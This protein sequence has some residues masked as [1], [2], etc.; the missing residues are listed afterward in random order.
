MLALSALQLEGSMNRPLV[1][2]TFTLTAAV[3]P[4]AAQPIYFIQD[5]GVLQGYISQ[6]Y[7]I[8]A[9]GQVAG[10]V[11]A[12][13]PGDTGT[14]R[15]APNGVITSLLPG[16]GSSFASDINGSGQVV[17][18]YTTGTATHAFR[19]TATGG[20]DPAADLGTLGGDNISAGGINTS[21]QV[22]G[23]SNLTPAGSVFHAFRTTATG[24][25]TAATDLTTLDPGLSSGGAAI[26]D[27]GQ[28]AGSSQFPGV[29]GYRAFRTTATGGITAA[30]NLG[31]LGGDSNAEDINA[32]GQVVGYSFLPGNTTIHAFRT[33][34]TGGIT[35]ASDLGSFSGS[36]YGRGINSAGVV[37]GEY[38]NL[39]GASLAF[40]YDTQMR[41]LTSMIR[42]N[43]DG[44]V[45]ISAQDINDAGQITGFGLR[46]PFYDYPHAFRL[47]PIPEPPSW[48]LVSLVAAG[49]AAIRRFRS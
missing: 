39:G 15:T 29:V 5:L 41:D 7:A 37:V 8:N 1:G 24:G 12:T 34:A 2:L 22:T 49:L 47:T 48:A 26:N 6:A 32:S 3:G 43:L 23:G 4:A 17:G 14:F 40:V 38:V 11:Y 21:G 20:L 35:A 46:R 33:T 42:D 25:V 30:S 9:S 31:S 13:N 10:A 27:A 19:T 18:R 28:V 45:L 44:W 36:S 16:G